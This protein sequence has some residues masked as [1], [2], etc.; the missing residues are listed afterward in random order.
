MRQNKSNNLFNNISEIDP[1]AY[2]KKA[3]FKRIA[4]ENQK[5]LLRKK[6]L[7]FCGFSVSIISLF[8]SILFFG[9]NIMT[10]DFW[11][12]GLLAFSDMKVV[13]TYWQEYLLSLLE[14]FPVEAMTF[15]MVPMFILLVLAKQYA[16]F[17]RN[18]EM[19][20]KYTKVQKI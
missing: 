4:K 6:M 5:Q 15:I 11:S 8:T 3:V 10:S 12:I 13:F 20:T 19:F 14:T 2:L 1:P 16:E 17:L 7:Y 18:Y 9:K